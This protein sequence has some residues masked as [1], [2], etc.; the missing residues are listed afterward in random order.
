MGCFDLKKKALILLTSFLVFSIAGS[1]AFVTGQE[2]GTPLIALSST[3]ITF[4]GEKDTSLEARNLTIIGLEDSVNVTL[5]PSDLYSNGTGKST[6]INLTIFGSLATDNYSFMTNK[7]EQTLITVTIS[8]LGKTG[9]YTGS[10]T[11]TATVKENITITNLPVV[12][13]IVP[14]NLWN[15]LVQ[16]SSVAAVAILIFIGLMVQDDRWIPKKEQI[17]DIHYNK[18]KISWKIPARIFLLKRKVW[19]PII[20]ILVSIIWIYLM[21]AAD[22]GGP[23]T[24][25][26]ALLVGPFVAYSV[27]V[28]K[29]IRTERLEK[30]KTSR[31]IR[32]DGI[33]KDLEL[34]GNL[35]GEMA[36]HCASFRPN[37]YE[38][39]LTKPAIDDSPRLLY[40]KTGIISR[41]VWDKSCRQG[42]V[43]DIHT[44]HLEKYYDFVPLYNQCYSQAMTL[45]TPE[46]SDTE[47]KRKE[48]EKFL[49]PFEAFRKV[50]GDLQEVLFV[51]LS[52]ILELYSKTTL[53]PMKLQYPRITR[54]LIYKLIDYEILKPIEKLDSLSKFKT[55]DI[56]LEIA[57]EKLSQK[58][59]ILRK[60]GR[61]LTP[62]EVILS[63]IQHA[64]ERDKTNG[65]E[66]GKKLIERS[67]EQFEKKLELKDSFKKNHQDRMEDLEDYNWQFKIHAFE[68]I[69]EVADWERVIDRLG[70]TEDFQ[71][72]FKKNNQGVEKDS[73]NYKDW[74]TFLQ[75]KMRSLRETMINDPDK[76]ELKAFKDFIAERTESLK[77]AFKNTTR[78]KENTPAFNKDFDIYLMND[79]EFKKRFNHYVIEEIV[80]DTIFDELEAVEKWVAVKFKEQIE[81]W[82]LTADDLEKIVESIYAEDEVPHFFRHMQDDFQKTYLK[83]KETIKRLPPK[84]P[85]MPTE[86]ELKEYKVTLGNIYKEPEKEGEKAEEDKKKE[87][88]PKPDPFRL[89]LDSAKKPP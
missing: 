71:E 84:I 21:V 26:N 62:E 38:E 82:E 28:V 47:E 76:R 52:Y 57:K 30:E 39:K 8:P 18:H 56:A 81:W 5:I 40:S 42:F 58:L 43:A 24:V 87:E 68:E 17:I 83:L 31:T 80:K 33:K 35:I 2:S 60:H 88:K 75:E 13:T 36:T 44:L 59:K 45:T 79:P 27:A 34:I 20:G 50:Y 29:D 19:V 6:S 11:I 7:S 48:N 55:E 12:V 46:K 4:Y 23:A 51:Y 72:E 64:L 10:I 1:I 54:T 3:N 77:E 25:F 67:K 85:P 32:D 49:K 16:W 15:S 63:K 41:D 66:F 73:P 69:G 53:S 14:V 22:F 86:S 61:G 70:K 65:K 9:T 89:V 74:K 37:F 78:L